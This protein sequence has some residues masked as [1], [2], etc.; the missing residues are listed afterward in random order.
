[1]KAEITDLLAA[2]SGG[3]RAA[4]DRLLPLVY[5][6]LRRVAARRLARERAGH[7]L[8]PTAL[9]HEA[10]LRLVEQHSAQWQGR[11]HFF[12]VAAELMRR[13]LVDH[14]RA[15]AAAK[16]GAGQTLVSLDAAREPRGPGAPDV[17]V[18][19]L[20]AALDRLAELDPR[21]ARIVEL[22][23]F[24]GLSVDETALILDLSPATVKRAWTM[25]RAWLFRELGGGR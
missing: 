10:Y 14:A 21:Q 12:G 6:E 7:T 4:L 13:I 22:R 23:Y 19:A 24:G 17:D 20:N 18:L 8:V 15:R 3:D 5:A 16:R 25:A 11:A 9:V 1:L 2:W